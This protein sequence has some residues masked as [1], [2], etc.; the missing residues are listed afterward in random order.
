[1]PIVDLSSNNTH[2][3]NYPVLA[4]YLKSDGMPGAI[5]KFTEGNWYNNPD[6]ETDW[7]GLAA[8]GVPLFQY[9]F[10]DTSPADEQIAYAKLYQKPNTIYWSDYEGSATAQTA[11]AVAQAL[12]TWSTLIVNPLYMSISKLPDFA[13]VSDILLWLADPALTPVTTVPGWVPTW[14]SFGMQTQRT[15]IPGISGLV[16]VTY[17]NPAV[18]SAI[19]AAMKSPP[20][21]TA[22]VAP[23]VTAPSPT[24]PESTPLPTTD[25][26]PVATVPTTTTISRLPVSWQ[27]DSQGRGWV[28][29]NLD[30]ANILSIVSTAPFP[31]TDGYTDAVSAT[32]AIASHNGLALVVWKNATPNVN[33]SF[34]V[35]HV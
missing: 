9:H 29:L 11:L 18:Y 20:E 22:V 27:T 26:V 28:L 7:N 33:N 3:I 19:V 23:T 15:S 1:M 12:N 35:V 10:C 31:P 5:I 32:Y 4:N 8:F 21:P 6:A 16:D 25:T 2:P 30:P 24:P 14:Q 17:A 34:V 13:N